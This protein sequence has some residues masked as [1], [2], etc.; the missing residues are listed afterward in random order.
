M[1]L[2]FL[3]TTP[4]TIFFTFFFVF[5]AA[6][7]GVPLNS[8]KLALLMSIVIFCLI[9]L[10]RW[11][12]N[13]FRL[14]PT[15]SYITVCISFFLM[16]Y[17]VFLVAIKQTA[18]FSLSYNIFILTFENILG[19]YIF[20]SVFLKGRS[21]SQ[22]LDVFI[23][24]GLF[25]S[26][27]IVVMFIN[28]PFREFIFNWFAN[29]NIIEMSERY[30]G[31][32]GF[33]IAGSVTYDFSVLL[34]IFMMFSAYQLCNSSK[35]QFFYV[36]AWILGFFSVMVSGR[37]GFL[38]VAFS[39]WIIF[40]HFRK[41]QTLIGV[42]KMIIIALMCVLA[43]LM[44][45]PGVSMIINEVLIPYAFEMFFSAAK[46]DGFNTSSTDLLAH[47]YFQVSE[48]TFWFGDARWLADGGNSYY[49]HTDAGYMRHML[50]YGVVGSSIL[51][52]LYGSVFYYL[53]KFCER[54]LKPLILAIAGYAF[55]VQVKGDYLVGSSMNIKV[56]FLLFVMVMLARENGKMKRLV[57]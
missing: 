36:L 42:S 22:V 2:N 32:R 29:E 51:Y 45:F 35:S 27:I 9:L 5:G 10:T 15:P 18:D 47:M 25:Q 39:L 12:R 33:G 48:S 7:K 54:K 30:G 8:A 52:V 40:I 19:S 56:F 50:F 34:S 26:L 3:R 11:L 4:V 23:W 46:G 20:Y 1:I 57:R 24:I 53:Y 37:T 43:S 14:A 41:T 55:I 13:D 6:V 28:L 38:G 49:M 31:V 17:T 21:S 16:C 44:F